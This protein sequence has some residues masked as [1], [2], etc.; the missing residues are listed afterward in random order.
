MKLQKDLVSNGKIEYWI[1]YCE[2]GAELKRLPSRNR[3]TIDF[4]DQDWHCPRCGNEYN[5]YHTHYPSEATS[6]RYE[7]DGIFHKITRNQIGMAENAGYSREAGSL[8][9]AEGGE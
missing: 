7:E 4:T 9:P 3:S 6:D 8:I 1:T 5:E 2:C